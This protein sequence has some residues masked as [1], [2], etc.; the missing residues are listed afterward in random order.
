MQAYEKPIDKLLCA[1]SAQDIV[2]YT[3]KNK[4]QT[5]NHTAT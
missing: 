5:F 3:Y 4:C 1:L 2:F